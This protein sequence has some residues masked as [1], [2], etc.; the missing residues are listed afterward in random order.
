MILITGGAGF[1]G[2]NFVHTWQ[3]QNSESIV[4]IDSL[5]YAGNLYNL[6][7]L[8]NNNLHHFICEDINNF[9]QIQDIISETKPRAIIHFAAESHVDRSINNPQEFINTNVIGTFN[10]L[11][12]SRIYYA[13][14]NEEAQKEFKFIHIST[15]EVYGSLDKHEPAFTE[16][17]PYAPNSPYSASK[18]SS[19]HLVRSY[20]H[21]YGLPCI[22]THCSNNYGAYQFPEKLI[23][24]IISN[25]LSGKELPIYGDGLNI[26]DW[27]HVEDH[28]EAII[29]ILNKGKIGEVYNI[30]GCNEKTNIEVVN[31]ICHIL[32]KLKPK[33]NNQSYKTQIK[34]VK[35][36]LG[37]DRRYAIDNSK[38]K[39]ELNWQP[40]YTFDIGIKQT[41]E[42]YLNNTL[43]IE[44]VNS[45]EY[46]DFNINKLEKIGN[47]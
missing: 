32:D 33:Q 30:G 42:W 28:C 22:I 8:L 40:K 38:I 9:E 7:G 41:V 16:S 3:K 46:Q 43:W 25:A 21:T 35:D 6:E 29:T 19:D 2:S 14:L 11:E 5:T 1:I 27:L 26:R 23:P 44:R 31:T 36:R 17:T 12:A 20:Y 13:S 10:L 45:L 39:N 24:L 47:E 18:A 4:N 37:H 15:D 34:F